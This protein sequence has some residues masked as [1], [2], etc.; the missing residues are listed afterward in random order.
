MDSFTNTHIVLS[1][2]IGLLVRDGGGSGSRRL[3][4][5]Y[6]SRACGANGVIV[7]SRDLLF[8]AKGPK[9]SENTPTCVEPL[10][11]V[12]NTNFPPRASPLYSKKKKNLERSKQILLHGCLLRNLA[13]PPPPPPPPPLHGEPLS[14]RAT[15][16]KDCG[17]GRSARAPAA[18][19][20]RERA[21][22]RSSWLSGADPSTDA[23][24]PPPPLP[25]SPLPF[26]HGSRRGRAP[27]HPA[28]ARDVFVVVRILRKK[29]RGED[30][31]AH[32]PLALRS[33]LRYARV[34]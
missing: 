11:P 7:K 21:S 15:S 13:P 9:R 6:S 23:A 32:Q 8:G 16:V 26:L 24:S 33:P 27:R 25:P 31:E 29:W 2:V 34:S 5:Y 22:A 30:A 1:V 12:R 20:A 18:G 19:S 14:A 28:V 4:G 3:S 10:E 17:V